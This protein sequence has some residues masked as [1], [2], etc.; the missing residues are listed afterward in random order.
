MRVWLMLTATLVIG[1][2]GL[3]STA[4]A[5]PVVERFHTTIDMNGAVLTCSSEDVVFTG[6]GTESGIFVLT[7]STV[8]AIHV[9]FNLSGVT[10]VGLTTG[11][12]YRVTGV[13]TTTQ[14]PSQLRSRGQTRT[15]G[16]RRGF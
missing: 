3:T 2:L 14:A 1:A 13:T 5:T 12:N 15:H 8:R 9:V 10:A 7:S 16:F 6:T 11:T 4:S